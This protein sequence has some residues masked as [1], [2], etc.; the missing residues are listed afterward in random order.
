MS[1]Q[2]DKLSLVL[3]V[4]WRSGRPFTTPL[5]PNLVFTTDNPNIRYN[6]P[7]SDNLP[8]FVRTDFSIKYVLVERE[9]LEIRLN[10]AVQN[11]FDRRNVLNRYYQ[12]REGEEG[13]FTINQIE[14]SSLRITPNFSVEV[15]F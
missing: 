1:Y 2:K 9:G 11:L 6:A 12:S 7:N 3:G 14:N 15:Q 8:S 10:G 4:Q 5:N 13:L